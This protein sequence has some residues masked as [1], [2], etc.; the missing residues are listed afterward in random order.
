MSEKVKVITKLAHRFNSSVI[1]DGVQ[2]HFNGEG[3]AELTSENAY[4][5]ATREGSNIEFLNKKDIETSVPET[6]GKEEYSRVLEENVVLKEEIVKLE[7]QIDLL[8]QQATKR[9]GALDETSKEIAALKEQLKATKQP[10]PNNKGG[11]NSKKNKEEKS[12]EVENPFS[13]LSLED[14]QTLCKDAGF[15]EA[16]WKDLDI[17]QIRKYL[18]KKDSEEQSKED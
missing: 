2:V 7:N 10:N 12:D 13:D 15:D 5:V 9:Q 6:V 3:V 1:V 8:K 11:K 18:A 4:K 14:C 17:D 16:E